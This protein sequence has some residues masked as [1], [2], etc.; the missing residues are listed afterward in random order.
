MCRS[1]RLLGCQ[2]KQLAA[3]DGVL[4]NVLYGERLALFSQCLKF[5]LLGVT[6]VGWFWSGNSLL[7]RSALPTSNAVP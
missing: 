3:I 1:A 7:H 5:V 2:A 4:E 6:C